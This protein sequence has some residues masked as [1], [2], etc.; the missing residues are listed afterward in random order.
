MRLN[1]LFLTWTVIISLILLAV[2]AAPPIL[3]NFQQFYGT[4]DNLPNG[5]YYFL[6]ARLGNQSFSTPIAADGKYGYASIFKVYGSSGTI[7]FTVTA[8]GRSEVFAGTAAF[9]SGAVTLLNLRYGTDSGRSAGNATSNAS[10]AA[11]TSST[12]STSSSR[13]SS[14]DTT[15]GILKP[16]QCRQNWV[17]GLWNDCLNGRQ[18]RSCYRDDQCAALTASG[19]VNETLPMPKPAESRDC[20]V[21][22]APALGSQQICSPSSQR[23]LGQQLQECFYDGQSWNTLESCPESCDSLTLSC[24]SAA[25]PETQQPFSLP[26]WLYIAAGALILIAIVGGMIFVVHKNSKY[27]PA[28]E[29]IRACRNKYIS[30]SQ[31]KAKLLGEGWDEKAV[32]KL[33][34]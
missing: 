7:N 26:V 17:C 13:R 19:A 23:C 1:Y 20:E 12:D 8:V 27:A 10:S 32:D 9:E 2:I 25:L 11:S 31:I 30:D 4:V 22:A 33:L 24:R 29:Y 21:S 18:T 16:K 3:T 14:T 15:S 34:K 28:K 5:T 6:K